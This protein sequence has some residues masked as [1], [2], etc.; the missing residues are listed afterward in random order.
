ML[1]YTS[2]QIDPGDNILLSK[3]KSQE[4]MDC[5][6]GQSICTICNSTVGNLSKHCGICNKCVE[7]FDHHC[8]WLNN[9]IGVKNY[10]YFI[11]LLWTLQVN[12]I[13]HII[14]ACVLF[15][16]YNEHFSEYSGRVQNPQVYIAFTAITFV[17]S[18]FVLGA[19]SYLIAFHSYIKCKGISTFEFILMR[20]DKKEAELPSVQTGKKE[21]D[22]GPEKDQA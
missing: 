2:T 9:C 1:A 5:E 21:K 10:K 15:A 8:K 20:R 7:E 4:A 17:E 11:A 19:N 14:F 13:V 3:G 22:N 16:D 6:I 18:L 12:L